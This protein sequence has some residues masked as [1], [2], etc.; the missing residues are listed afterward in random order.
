VMAPL[1]TVQAT[2]ASG[3]SPRSTESRSIMM[4]V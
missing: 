2:P 4:V 3:T 1:S